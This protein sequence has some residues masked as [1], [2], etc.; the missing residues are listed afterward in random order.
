MTDDPATMKQL[1]DLKKQIEKIVGKAI[2]AEPSQLINLAHPV[3]SSYYEEGSQVTWYRTFFPGKFC[4]SPVTLLDASGHSATGPDGTRVFLLSAFI[5]S[6]LNSFSEPAFLL[7][8]PKTASACFITLTHQIVPDQN[9]PGYNDVQITARSWG[10]S[11]T[12]AAN[13]PFDWRCRVVSNPII[14]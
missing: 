10:P 7:A 4:V 6:S 9:S 2:D 14:E 1:A 8:T 5:C 11:G 3:G 12:A 13:V